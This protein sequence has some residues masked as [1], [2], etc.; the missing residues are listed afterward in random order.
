M[1]RPA[2]GSEC[3]GFTADVRN[4]TTQLRLD[5]Q[6][7]QTHEVN[8]TV[9]CQA[10]EQLEIFG[11]PWLPFNIYVHSSSPGKEIYDSSVRKPVIRYH[12]C[13]V[14]VSMAP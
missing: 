11:V 3:V 12:S 7:E 2:G 8:T 14:S 6:S 13:D 1:T 9:G 4:G 5:E 10:R